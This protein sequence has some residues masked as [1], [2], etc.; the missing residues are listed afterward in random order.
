MKNCKNCGAEIDEKEIIHGQSGWDS[1]YNCVKCN[2]WTEE[3]LGQKGMPTRYFLYDFTPYALVTDDANKALQSIPPALDGQ[4]KEWSK[5]QEMAKFLQ[6]SCYG[7]IQKFV[8][9]TGLDPD[10]AK[11]YAVSMGLVEM[12]PRKEFSGDYQ[13][14][15]I[16][17][18]AELSDN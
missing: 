17:P 4:F 1:Y 12:K 8:Q 3:V 10:L 9:F 6:K 5:Y 14:V 18:P 13:K 16:V 15:T 11:K 7:H 2:W